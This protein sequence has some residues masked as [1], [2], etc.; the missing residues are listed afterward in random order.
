MTPWIIFP[1][2]V[3]RAAK[4]RLRGVLSEEQRSNL[5]RT[6]W[7]NTWRAAVCS[8]F[9]PRIIIVSREPEVQDAAFQTGAVVLDDPDDINLNRALLC[10][11]EEAVRQG[12]PSVLVI[13]VDLP[14]L[15][16]EALDA[17]AGKLPR[18]SSSV[19]LVPDRRRT[20]TNILFQAPP[21]LMPFQFG[22]DSFDRHKAA[23]RKAGVE[24][25]EIV[26]PALTMDLDLPE[27]LILFEKENI[28]RWGQ[29]LGSGKMDS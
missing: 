10:G 18:C 21:S 13:P 12:A 24:P 27:D 28:F 2:K 20:G 17:L 7:Q 3:F 9:F 6:L 11:A 16:T 5:A 25:L 19:A 8:V 26:D 23:A 4:M 15:T 29:A 14:L 22:P 1:V